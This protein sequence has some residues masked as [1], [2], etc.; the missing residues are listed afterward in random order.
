MLIL[1]MDEAMDPWTT[2]ELKERG[3]GVLDSAPR[4]CHKVSQALKLTLD[5]R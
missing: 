5:G 4:I 2:C 1:E 3:I